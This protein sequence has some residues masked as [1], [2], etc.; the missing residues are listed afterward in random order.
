MFPT[1]SFF[2]GVLK[3]FRARF[4]SL[5]LSLFQQSLAA[6]DRVLTKARVSKENIDQVRCSLVSQFHVSFVLCYFVAC[7]RPLKIISLLVRLS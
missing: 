5:C 7:G 3:F 4:E 6:I 2:S 1:V